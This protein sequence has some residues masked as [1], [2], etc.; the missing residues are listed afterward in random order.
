[1]E[2]AHLIERGV[3]GALLIELFTH[4]G[5][6]S[7]VTADMKAD[8]PGEWLYHCHVVDHIHAGMQT[9]YQILP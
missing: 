9:T 8:N 2:R 6:G 3:D 4:A 7:M 5:S 1:M